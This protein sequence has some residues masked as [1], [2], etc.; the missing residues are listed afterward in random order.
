MQ[1]AYKGYIAIL[2]TAVGK[3]LP[4]LFGMI[5]PKKNTSIVAIIVDTITVYSS[6]TS[7][8]TTPVNKTEHNDVVKTEKKI[9]TTLLPIKPVIIK[10]SNLSKHFKTKLALFFPSSAKTFSL[11]LFV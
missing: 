11:I 1:R 9:L 4:M 2:E 5:S 6:K 7:G 8:F 3:A 10:L